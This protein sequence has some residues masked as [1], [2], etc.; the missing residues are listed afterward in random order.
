MDTPK[1][2]EFFKFKPKPDEKGIL[3]FERMI[4][5]K[6]FYDGLVEYLKAQ[7]LEGDECS[8]FD[9]LEYLAVPSGMNKEKEIPKYHNI[10]AV[11]K[12]G[13]CE[14]YYFRIAVTYAHA[15]GDSEIIT[16][17]INA[18]TFSV[19]YEEALQINNVFNRFIFINED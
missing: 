11:C 2:L 10:F 7:R 4:T 1:P 16:D 15:D 17:I 9:L 19:G 18:K 5:Y 6:E 13:H 3:T 12:V 14:G 8:V